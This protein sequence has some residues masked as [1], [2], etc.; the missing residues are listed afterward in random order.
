[1]LVE[2]HAMLRDI[3]TEYIGKLPQVASCTA[4]P[5]AEAA[6]IELDRMIGNPPHLM[7]IDLSLPGMSGIEL[8]RKLKLTRPTLRCAI[9]SGHRS[10]AYAGE[11]LAAGALAYMLKGD[12]IEIERGLSA[13]M[14]GERYVSRA[15]SDDHH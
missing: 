6:L 12:P 10:R 8:I 3:L 15:L 9:L 4:S 2:D 14:R 11:A 5:S 13:I 1:M 7:L